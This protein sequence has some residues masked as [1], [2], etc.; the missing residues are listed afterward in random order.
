MKSTKLI[1]RVDEL[2]A[3][4]KRREFV[5]LCKQ[6][7][8]HTRVSNL[9]GISKGLVNSLS[10]GRRDVRVLH[11]YALRYLAAHPELWQEDK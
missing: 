2:D 10:S 6:I 9:L 3:A 7:G 8:S 1:D 11:I 4:E 5:N